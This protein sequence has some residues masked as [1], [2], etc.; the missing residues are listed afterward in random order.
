MKAAVFEGIEDIRIREVE[1]P[2][3]DRDDIVVRVKS[4][5][6]C[7]SDIRNFHTGLKGNVTSQI[8]GHEIAGV[9][10]EVGPEV[11]RF[12]VGD[13]VAIAPDVS[14]GECYYCKRNLVNL[15]V[16][17]RMI[18][19]HWPGGFAEYLHLP[20]EVLAHGMVHHMPEGLPFDA[21]ALSEPA[22]SVLAAQHNADIGLSDTVLIIG[23]GPIG[24]L[25]IEMARARGASR[26]FMVGLKRL[27]AAA[28]FSPDALIDAA[29][30]NP[31]QE[32]LKLTDGLGADVAICAN[33]VASTQEQAVE[34]V[35]KR[36]KVVLFGGVPKTSPMTTLNSNLIHYNELR[37]LGAFSYPAY[38]HQLALKVI[39]DGKITAD[40]YLDY[41]L[42]L[43]QISEG[44]R[45]AE[46]GEVLKVII[47]P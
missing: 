19:T 28:T 1:R 11:T 47:N 27:K 26:V 30:Q 25:H 36:G 45:A 10:D 43:D 21:A 5:G 13:R 42:S 41:R 20:R 9:V 8:M 29:T 7:G 18:G 14:C 3:C 39:A 32:V 33:P 34:A 6:I 37:I 24:C 35:R 15:C 22:S 38:I 2:R 23:D 17:H 12:H 44:F 31:V 46:A 16:R 40:R 4:C